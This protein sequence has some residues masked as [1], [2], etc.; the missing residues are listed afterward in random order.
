MGASGIYS[1]FFVGRF[2]RIE[3]C[4]L[5]PWSRLPAGCSDSLRIF[6]PKSHPPPH[7]PLLTIITLYI[8]HIQIL[9]IYVPPFFSPFLGLSYP[10]SLWSQSLQSFVALSSYTFSSS[11]TPSS[12]LPLALRS[13]LND[14]PLP[15][16]GF[17]FLNRNLK[18][19][20]I[21]SLG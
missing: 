2:F 1:V 11:N 20:L 3:V 10:G 18:I 17:S 8:A 12:K 6:P 14:F 16:F 5:T 7:L 15:G 21:H 13:T 9:P 19:R 4:L